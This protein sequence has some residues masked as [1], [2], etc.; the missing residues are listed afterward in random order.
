MIS[1]ILIALLAKQPPQHSYGRYQQGMLDRFS[2]DGKFFTSTERPRIPCH[3]T[4]GS[5][6]GQ[7]CYEFGV[8]ETRQSGLVWSR[9]SYSDQNN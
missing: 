3:A 5:I 9:I 2:A 8:N 6:S 1:D 7:Q 4:P